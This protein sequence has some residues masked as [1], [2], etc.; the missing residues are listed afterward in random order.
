MHRVLVGVSGLAVAAPAGVFCFLSWERAD[1]VA[2]VISAL[3]SMAA[4]AATLWTL[5]SGGS[6]AQVSVSA[7]GP[8]DA[9][10]PGSQ[11]NS[12]VISP[13][14]AQN[15]VSVSGTGDAKADQGGS[16]NTGFMAP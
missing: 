5:R 4:L 11:A 10:G 13:S 2:G 12:G 15:N 3:V 8:A 6:G 14:S 16:A 1:Q 7:T 9:T